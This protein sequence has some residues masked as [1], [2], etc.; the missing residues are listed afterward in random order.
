MDEDEVAFL[1]RFHSIEEHG[2][3]EGSHSNVF[4]YQ[5]EACEMLESLREDTMRK[6][7]TPLSIALLVRLVV[8]DATLG[9]LLISVE[10]ETRGEAVLLRGYGILQRLCE[11]DEDPPSDL[12][13][14]EIPGA[15]LADVFRA[16]LTRV[17]AFKYW[18]TAPAILLLNGFALYATKPAA[19]VEDDLE[20]SLRCLERA[21]AV[22]QDWDS[23]NNS[24]GATTSAIVKL[25]INEAGELDLGDIPA[26]QHTRYWERYHMECSRIVTL[27]YLAQALTSK[28]DM[29]QAF[30]YCHITLYLQ[31]VLRKET[32][33]KEWARNTLQLSSHYCNFGA[34]PQALHCLKAAET[35]M[36]MSNP[37]EETAGIVSWSYGRYHKER[38]QHYADQRRAGVTPPRVK[39]C[40]DFSKGWLDFPVEGVPACSPSMLAPLTDY[41]EVREEFKCGLRRYNDALKYYPFDVL[42]TSHV[43]IQQEIC[44]LYDVLSTFETDPLRVIA[45][46]QR[47]ISIIEGFPAH[48]SF[49][50]YPTLVR[51][52]HYDIGCLREHLIELRIT[53]RERCHKGE[54]HAG[55]QPIPDKNLNKLIVKAQDSF[56]RFCDSWLQST[57]E[58]TSPPT[59]SNVVVEEGCRVAFFRALM[60][61]ARL[62]TV[63]A[64]ST[65]REEYEGIR[66][67]CEGYEKA[68]AFAER[69]KFPSDAPASQREVQYAMELLSILQVKRID[70]YNAFSCNEQ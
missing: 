36:P 58:G 42:C 52:L 50:A 65:P 27:F 47:Q 55:E 6:S 57:V 8:V 16:P 31:L 64:Y 33:Y 26:A 35:L 24:A 17:R 59:I 12:L 69:N 62:H 4:Q 34:F 46:V 40:L 20:A 21:E 28:G 66:L 54:G 2:K 56:T 68:I 14:E 43:E 67:A 18:G 49:N 9:A 13:L 7:R 37:D 30:R 44:R 10:E 29:V 61:L 38:L 23:P 60:R 5:Q 3:R 70:L 53:Q 1:K 51:Q 32:S 25:P 45:L 19:E 22:Y 48:L 39:G 63:A 41:G 11:T 15:L